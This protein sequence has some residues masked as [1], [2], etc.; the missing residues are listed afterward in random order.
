MHAERKRENEI[1]RVRQTDRQ[2]DRVRQRQRE[3]ETERELK[4]VSA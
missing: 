4:T 3:T 2:T 1:M